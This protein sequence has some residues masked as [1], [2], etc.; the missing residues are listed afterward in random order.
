MKKQKQRQ[1]LFFFI[2]WL[3]FHQNKHI[4][5]RR[6]KQQVCF[7]FSPIIAVFFKTYIL[8][9][10]LT[11]WINILLSKCL[12]IYSSQVN[13]KCLLV[14]EKQKTI[15]LFISRFIFFKNKQFFRERKEKKLLCLLSN[16]CLF[17]EHAFKFNYSL[18]NQEKKNCYT[19]RKRWK[20]YFAFNV[21][22]ISFMVI[23]HI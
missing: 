15:F 18:G 22:A 11:T 4:F 6:K 8:S 7:N 19:I 9:F 14:K 3:I 17:L 21:S 23:L 5:L 12:M 2:S 16:Y 10:D 13:F 1:K 20:R